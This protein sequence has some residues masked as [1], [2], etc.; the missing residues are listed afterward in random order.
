MTIA[1]EPEIKEL[2][3]T[4][5]DVNGDRWIRRRATGRACWAC[6]CGE[7]GEMKPREEA[8]TEAQE[9]AATHLE[10]T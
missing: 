10:E 4:G 2:E 6:V 5:L 7:A 3:P 8:A 1:F 9:H